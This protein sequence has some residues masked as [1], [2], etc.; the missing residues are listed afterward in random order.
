VDPQW[1]FAPCRE[2]DALAL[3]AELGVSRTTAEVLIRRG[4]TSADGAR[5][6]MEQDG[7]AHDPFL[8]GDMEAACARIEA[9][10]AAGARICVHGDYD[11]DGICA[12]ALAVQVLEGLGAHVEWHLPSRFEEGYGVGVQALE[13]VAAS[14][15]RLLLTVDCGITAVSEVERAR[16]LGM[17][18]IVTDHHRP[19]AE[20][21]DALRVVTRPSDYPFPELCG[22]GVVFKLAEALHRR[23]GRD[24][25]ELERHLD[26]V[27]L[28]TVADV[29]PLL[30]ENR[31]LVRAGLRRLARTSRPGLRALMSAAR[32]DRT[33]IGAGDLGFRLGP[34]I[35]A[36]GRLG[37]PGD[38]LELLLTDDEK[39]ARELAD[40]LETLNR[41]RQQVESEI[42]EG[43]VE[44][45]EAADDDWR[46]R[47]AYVLA[48]SEWHEGVIGIVASRLVERY[49]RPVVLIAVGDD[50]AKGSGRSIPAF[51]L[52]GG[53]CAA[54][55]HLLRYGGHRAAAG[56]SIDPAAID[57][58]S[59][60][61]AAH[62][63]AMLTDDDLRPSIRIDAV[64]APGEV[65]LD[66]VDEL[67]RLEPFGLGN[68]G[69]T[70]LA[71]AATLRGVGA[72]GEGRHLRATVELGGF[73]CGA[74]GFGMGSRADAL[75]AGG[76]VDVA[77]RLGR[78]EWNGAV[79]AQMLLRALVSLPELNAD[80]PP[81]RGGRSHTGATVDLRGRGVQVATVARLAASGE[82]VLVVVA[83]RDR[84]RRML[85]GPLS[86]QRF[87]GGTVAL[88]E[89]DELDG[90]E[91]FAEAVALD[92]PSDAQSTLALETLAARSRVHLVWGSAEI[93]FAREVAELRA[94]LRP[95]LVAVWRAHRTGSVPNLPPE[96][97][98]ACLAVLA[99]LG[100]DPAAS[101]GAKVDLERSPTYRQALE[102]F[103]LVE[104]HLGAHAVG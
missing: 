81:P 57:D 23:A 87:G 26:L 96:T 49:G 11:V 98:A 36:A 4:H 70:L 14:G 41:R 72:I 3:A 64:L 29:V 85:R 101:P 20:L 47:R 56:L 92:P 55:D 95:A 13:R 91:G 48:S 97:I 82:D 15:V 74:V 12:T 40:K 45:V 68:P 100:L 34:R 44:Q 25:A 24:P 63:A 43:A 71:P 94:P 6:F 67:A 53:L 86:P 2:D 76:R 37:H 90:I 77:Y 51:D 17:D 38:A 30:D 59:N 75:Q 19:A 93:E 102:R 22:S 103:A 69:V 7:P 79:A 104:R 18:V 27:A 32:V 83:D 58:F 28:A 80:P 78:N 1:T 66:L 16:E 9:A 8:L 84:R 33:R 73:R 31:R 62:A 54:G 60:A 50:E 65:S 5:A 88:A 52:H 46:G 42:L 35:N 21:P 39:R 61:L 89:Y 99:E 10:I